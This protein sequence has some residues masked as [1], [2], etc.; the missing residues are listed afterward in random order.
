MTNTGAPG[1]RC[2]R[3]R[4]LELADAVTVGRKCPAEGRGIRSR[5]ANT[6][7][8]APSF[9]DWSSVWAAVPDSGTRVAPQ[10]L[11]KIFGLLI[12]LGTPYFLAVWN[13]FSGDRH[14]VH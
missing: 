3:D 1:G 5:P 10:P 12:G 13:V 9:H 2:A 7:A 8:R 11:A 4:Q 14:L 6:F